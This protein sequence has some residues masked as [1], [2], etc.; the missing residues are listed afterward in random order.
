MA[1]EL[2]TQLRESIRACRAL[3]RSAL[4]AAAADEIARLEFEI[5]ELRKE[6]TALRLALK[7]R[8]VNPVPELRRFM[9]VASARIDKDEAKDA[10]TKKAD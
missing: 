10:A 9:A 1:S 5:L 6:N 7:H 4:L 3:D 8:G 2:V